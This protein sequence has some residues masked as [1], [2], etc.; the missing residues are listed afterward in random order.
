MDEAKRRRL[1][2]RGWK[3]GNETDFLGLSEE[4]GAIVELKTGFARAI[5]DVRIRRKMTQQQLGKML[6][7]SQSR[8]AKIEAA[9]ASVSIDLMIRSLLKMGMTKKE[10]ASYISAPRRS[11]AA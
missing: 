11:Q 2:S 8:V 3:V 4:E 7:S 10:L 6:G 5:R 9:D 1:R